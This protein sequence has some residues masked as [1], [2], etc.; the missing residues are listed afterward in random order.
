LDGS[1]VTATGVATGSSAVF[2]FDNRLS[3][4]FA[5]TGSETTVAVDQLTGNVQD[6]RFLALI[7]HDLAGGSAIVKTYPTSSRVTPTAIISGTITSSD[8]MIFDAGSVQSGKQFIDVELTASGTNTMKIGELGLFS[9]F[10]SPRA[11]SVN[12]PTRIS[13]RRV[14]I[15]LP[16]GERISISHA[17]PV[18]VKTFR[19][20]GLTEA[21]VQ[22]WIDVYDSAQGIKLVILVDDESSVFPTIMNKLLPTTRELDNFSV[23]LE[24]TEIRL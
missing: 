1:T 6:F 18:R 20:T 14:F 13:P 3:F 19:I 24:F 21:Q 12:V 7:D 15:D 10:T 5:T 2:L 9:Q 23:D 22:T 11:P 17:Q 8:P 4:A 16:N